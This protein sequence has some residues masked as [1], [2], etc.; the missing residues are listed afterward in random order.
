MELRGG[1]HVSDEAIV[2]ACALEANGHALTVMEG[3]L[4]VSHGATLSP[5]DRAAITRHR[6]HLMAIAAY[7]VQIV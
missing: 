3:K 2:L 6:L 7:E 4:V 1:L 5:E